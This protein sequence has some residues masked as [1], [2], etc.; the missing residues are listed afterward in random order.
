MEAALDRLA[1]AVDRRLAI[2]AAVSARHVHLSRWDGEALFGPGYCPVPERPL[3]RPGEYLC[4]ERL[5]L[6]GPGGA[7]VRTALLGP[8]REKSQAEVSLTEGRRLGLAPP[9]RQSG[10]SD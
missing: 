7:L 5:T 9:V 6:L 8:W 3:G 10:S 1:R 4:R 2:P